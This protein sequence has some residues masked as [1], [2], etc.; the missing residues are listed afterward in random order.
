M[1]GIMKKLISV[2]RAP[3]GRVLQEWE[4]LDDEYSHDWHEAVKML[5]NRL[6]HGQHSMVAQEF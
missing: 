1:N 3:K 2:G 6:E 4:L 5:Q